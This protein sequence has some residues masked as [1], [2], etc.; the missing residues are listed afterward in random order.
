MKLVQISDCHLFASPES[1][2][3]GG[4]KPA[5]SLKAVLTQAIVERPD[6]LLFTG[7]ITGDDSA[8]SYQL[9]LHIVRSIAGDIPWRVVPGN[10]DNNR[11]FNDALGQYWLTANTPWHLRDT[12][13]HGLD[14]RYEGTQGIVKQDQLLMVSQNISR[15][16]NA[17]HLLAIHHH[18]VAI[19]SWMDNHAL[20]NT[21]ALATWLEEQPVRAILHGHV[22]AETEKVLS[23]VPVFGVPSSSWQWQRSDEFGVAT[24]APGYRVVECA[25]PGVVTTLV[26]RITY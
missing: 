14:T 19:S 16:P 21:G 9:F 10:H 22:H 5:E 24:E 4:I 18:P 13:L 23:R 1:S 20:H 2:G 8:A 3:Y 6:G 25:E 12:Y 7:D 17:I 15:L 11:F 26:H